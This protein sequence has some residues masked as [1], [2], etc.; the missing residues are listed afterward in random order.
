[1]ITEKH[2]AGSLKAITKETWK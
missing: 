2:D 1:M